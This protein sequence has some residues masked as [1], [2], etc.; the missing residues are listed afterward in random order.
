[1][2]EN[3]WREYLEAQK[4]LYKDMLVYKWVYTINSNERNNC[5]ITFK[6]NFNKIN[7][8]TLLIYF[9]LAICVGAIASY[10]I[11]LLP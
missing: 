3:L 7:Q 4:L 10:L 5:L 6:R 11:Y 2:E 9:V 8:W 1:M